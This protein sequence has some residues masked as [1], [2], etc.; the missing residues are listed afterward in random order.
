MTSPQSAQLGCSDVRAE[1]NESPE[2][3]ARRAAAEFHK[4]AFA[5]RVGLSTQDLRSLDGTTTTND[6]AA[7]EQMNG[8][9]RDITHDGAG[10]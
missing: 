1:R 5:T 4:T 8:V 6:A 7:R 3:L 10:P 9:L 2:H